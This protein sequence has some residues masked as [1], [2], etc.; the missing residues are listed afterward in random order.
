VRTTFKLEPYITG[1]LAWEF[2]ITDFGTD[3]IFG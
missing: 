2:D 3:T 1:A